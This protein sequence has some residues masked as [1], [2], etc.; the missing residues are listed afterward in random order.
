[1]PDEASGGSTRREGRRERRVE[2]VVAM[3]MHG[4]GLGPGQDLVHT[5]QERGAVQRSRAGGAAAAGVGRGRGR[6]GGRGGI[7]RRAARGVLR[8]A[9]AVA[10][11]IQGWLTTLEAELKGGVTAWS[12]GGAL[13]EVAEAHLL[14]I[15][16]LERSVFF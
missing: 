10:D 16:A 11:A 2:R 7:A 9:M 12:W 6:G 3:R 13:Y 8:E 5:Q 1:M 14:P 15:N 4:R